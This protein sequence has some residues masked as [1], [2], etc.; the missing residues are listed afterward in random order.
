[1]DEVITQVTGLLAFDFFYN[2]HF[3]VTLSHTP[4]PNDAIK[5]QDTA[6]KIV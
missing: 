6:H 5:I 1:M 2:T 3:R 4:W